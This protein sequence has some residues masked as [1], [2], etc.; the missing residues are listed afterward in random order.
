MQQLTTVLDDAADALEAIL[1]QLTDV[2]LLLV[3]GTHHLVDLGLLQLE[4]SVSDFETTAARAQ[5]VLEAEGFESFAAATA[6]LAPAERISVEQRLDT[7]SARHRDVRVALACTGG[8]AERAVM[9]AREHLAEADN[10]P[11]VRQRHPFL[12]GT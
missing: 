10:T 5:D 6:G 7:V 9:E 12:T 8:I 4:Q 1:T 11:V 3:S 2:R